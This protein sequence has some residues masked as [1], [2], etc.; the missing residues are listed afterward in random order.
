[1]KKRRERGVAGKG[2]KRLVSGV[3]IGGVLVVLGVGIGVTNVMLHRADEEGTQV[4]QP[5]MDHEEN[6][7]SVEESPQR[8]DERQVAKEVYGSG[9]INPE[10]P[11]PDD[12]KQH[13]SEPQPDGGEQPLPVPAAEEEQPLPPAERPASEEVTSTGDAE[14]GAT[15]SSADAPRVEEETSAQPTDQ[16]TPRDDSTPEPDGTAQ[17][18]E[19]TISPTEDPT[20]A[21]TGD[22]VMYGGGSGTPAQQALWSSWITHMI[23]RGETK[24]LV[25]ML[26]K[27]IRAIAPD[28]IAGERLNYSSYKNSRILMNAVELC[29]LTK[30][31]GA[32][33]LDNFITREKKTGEV[34]KNS[35][36]KFMSWLLMDRSRPLHRLLQAFVYHSGAPE[37]FPRTLKVFY[38]L[39]KRAPERDRTRYMNLAI[40]CSLVREEVAHSRGK[41]RATN[42]KLLDIP[43]LYDFF[44]KQ[45]ILN[46]LLTNIQKLTVT[47]LLHVVDVRL[48]LS[49][50]R[51]VKTHL[52]YQRQ[53]WGATYS[54]VRYLMERATQNVNPYVKYT[55][56][57][58]LEEGGVCQEQAY[59]CATS[60]KTRGLPAVIITGDGDRG[61]HAWVALYTS[62][63]NGWTTSG[64]YGYK[65]GRYQDP[66]SGLSLHESVLLNRDEK[67]TPERLEPALNCMVLSDY[68]CRIQCETQAVGAARYVT[69]AFPQ[70]TVSWR[71]LVSVMELCGGETV[72]IS[73]WRRL[74]V[75]LTHQSKKNKELLDLM[76][77]VQ[78]DHVMEGK[79]D[80]V[81]M[82]A[83]KQSSR[84][85]DELI[86][87]G[88]IDLAMESLQRQ[89]EIFVKQEDYR[90]LAGFFKPYLKEYVSKPNV[91]G[92]VLELYMNMLDVC[93]KKIRSKTEMDEKHREQAVCALWRACAKDVDALY[94]KTAFSSEDFFA[95]KKEAGIMRSIAECWRL[96]GDEKKAKRLEEIAEENY[97]RSRDR[98]TN[99]KRESPN[100]SKKHWES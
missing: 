50:F 33:K 63:K 91:F 28:L 43:E 97:E 35:P 4:V 89:A 96:A 7:L 32:E 30:L 57:E 78:N 22:L 80:N 37:S 59:F 27:R 72:N 79:R 71:N 49:E 14:D 54:R 100:T 56:A 11:Q 64:S 44:R 82:N 12:A 38:T 58:I 95:I 46:A 34:S 31:V 61:P 86:Q 88:R 73:A 90:G 39:W 52:D 60:A 17:T 93:A 98:N 9:E 45:D 92:D 99:K 83:L 15:P 77:A 51:W 55:F 20:A 41:L 6:N 85:L 16:A 66:C 13:E 29:L 21:Y 65:T 81:K 23:E 70:L 18:P 42:E 47:D 8:Q 74:Y 36:D 24:V 62:E 76:Q 5:P 68:L 19:K 48:P 94:T 75:E 53:N 67:L 40:A 26:E 87:I 3:I 1:M 2:N 69:I 10:T 25:P 84:K